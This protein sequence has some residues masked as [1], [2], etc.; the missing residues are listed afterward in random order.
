M[1]IVVSVRKLS[2]IHKVVFGET[3]ISCSDLVL[4]GLS[5][6]HDLLERSVLLAE[7]IDGCILRKQR[8]L[9]VPYQALL[10]LF[11][12]CDTPLVG[13]SLTLHLISAL[14]MSLGN[15]DV[16]HF[17]IILKLPRYLFANSVVL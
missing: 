3:L 17:A 11:E 5:R 15:R 2:Q 6:L 9:E 4:V 14:C 10:E 13:F 12:L 8:A 16:V 1:L 7:L